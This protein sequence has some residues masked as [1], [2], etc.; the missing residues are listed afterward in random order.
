METAFRQIIYEPLC[1]SKDSGR[2]LQSQNNSW[3]AG[4]SSQNGNQE[5]SYNP[6]RWLQR[7]RLS[8]RWKRG[9]AKSKASLLRISSLNQSTI[10]KGLKTIIA[11][12][13]QGGTTIFWRRRQALRPLKRTTH[14]YFLRCPT[15]DQ[16]ISSWRGTSHLLYRF[17][18]EK[19]C[20]PS[21]NG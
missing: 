14:C 13:W 15:R 12:S 9:T 10:R 1:K 19:R 18:V 4:G 5:S 16:T 17:S 8:T 6:T 2:R 7:S 3:E 20:N 11:Y 21:H